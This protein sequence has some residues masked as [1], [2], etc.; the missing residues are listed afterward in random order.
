MVLISLDVDQKVKEKVAQMGLRH[1]G[2]YLR[3]FESIVNKNSYE[4]ALEEMRKKM[5]RLSHLLDH[6]VVKSVN[7]EDQIKELQ[8]QQIK[9]KK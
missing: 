8:K 5:S 6:Y 9:K 7:L 2:V 1:R 3:G 4:D